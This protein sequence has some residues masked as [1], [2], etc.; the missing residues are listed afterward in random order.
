MV[1]YDAK[2]DIFKTG[3]KGILQTMKKLRSPSLHYENRVAEC[4]TITTKLFD[5]F[6]RRILD[7]FIHL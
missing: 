2:Q 7:P 4:N 1:P 3:A 6:K 5:R